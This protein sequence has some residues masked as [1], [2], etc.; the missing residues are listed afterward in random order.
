MEEV[1]GSKVIDKDVVKR[2]RERTLN[3]IENSSKKEQH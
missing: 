3:G 1:R 2:Y